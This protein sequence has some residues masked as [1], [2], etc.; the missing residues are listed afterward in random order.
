MPSAKPRAIAEEWMSIEQLSALLGVARRTLAKWRWLKEGPPYYSFG[1][2][3]RYSVPDVEEWMGKQQRIAPDEHQQEPGRIARTTVHVQTPKV[4]R[5]SR[6]G[7]YRTKSQTREE[8]R[9]RELIEA[10]VGNPETK[11]KQS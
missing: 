1:R 5:K 11:K 4:I 8:Y 6:I 10:Q 9:R 3:I 7:G 2:S